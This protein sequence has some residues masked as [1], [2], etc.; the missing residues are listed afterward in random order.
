MTELMTSDV[1]GAAA[2]T[3]KVCTGVILLEALLIHRMYQTGCQI[4]GAL[5]LTCSR[6]RRD[7]FLA[8]GHV[9]MAMISFLIVLNIVL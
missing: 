7:E 6:E 3:T 4:V 9:T 2:N 8:T 1:Y 5:K